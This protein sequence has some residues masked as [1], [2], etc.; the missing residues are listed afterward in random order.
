MDSESV[1]GGVTAVLSVT[2][3]RR[4]LMPAVVCPLVATSLLPCVQRR[5]HASAATHAG[6]S[7][8][9]ICYLQSYNIISIGDCFASLTYSTHYTRDTPEESAVSY[10][11]AAGESNKQAHVEHNSLIMLLIIVNNVNSIINRR[12]SVERTRTRAH[13]CTLIHN[14]RARTCTIVITPTYILS[15]SVRFL[16]S[17]GNRSSEKYTSYN[18][19]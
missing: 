1:I 2:V 3:A 7:E 18:V 15:M 14:A 10:T 16:G 9:N 13:T 12:R 4:S 8:T 17:C 5:Q 11:G 19:A 6:Q